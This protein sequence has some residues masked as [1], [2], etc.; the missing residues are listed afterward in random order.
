MKRYAAAAVICLYTKI[1]DMRAKRI[2]ARIQSAPDAPTRDVR[3][4]QL[5]AL[6]ERLG[7][8]AMATRSSRMSPAM[9]LSTARVAVWKAAL[10]YDQMRSASFIAYALM[11]ARYDIRKARTAAS[12]HRMVV[13]V[14]R[15]VMARYNRAIAG[16]IEAE[17]S[18][19]HAA[20]PDDAAAHGV[21]ADDYR[22][23]DALRRFESAA[24]A[25]VVDDAADVEAVVDAEDVIDVLGAYDLLGADAGDDAYVEMTSRA[26]RRVMRRR[27]RE[28]VA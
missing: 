13:H 14:P 25:V 21:D 19:G 28:A 10:R 1:D 11:K 26:A 16:I 4:A 9:A 20:T 18:V 8:Y 2:V 12:A 22:L 24:R 17:L 3:F 6:L 27:E 5:D 7:V 15:D 23:Y